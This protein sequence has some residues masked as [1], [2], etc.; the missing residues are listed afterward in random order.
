MNGEDFN[1][2]FDELIEGHKQLL[3][4][5]VIDLDEF[6]QRVNR[7]N[8]M[9]NMIIEFADVMPTLYIRLA[10]LNASEGE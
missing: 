4:Q 7:E 10:L 2:Y 9:R 1:R 5:G 8:A 6:T 3:S